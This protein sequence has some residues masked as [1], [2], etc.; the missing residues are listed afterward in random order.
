M[1]YSIRRTFVALCAGLGLIAHAHAKPPVSAFSD[2]PDVRAA[3]LSPD[4][5][6]VAFISHNDGVDS[7]AIFDF[8]T[9]ET[10]ALSQVTDL[11]VRDISFV[12]DRYL[13]LLVSRTMR[14]FGV[15]DQWEQSAAFS[16][17]LQE[18]DVVKLLQRTDGLYPYQS[19]L[20]R[21]VGVH[22]DGDRV[23]M[24]AFMGENN[25]QAYLGLLAVRLDNGRG[26]EIPG[27]RGRHD[28]IDW[29]ISPKGEPLAREDLNGRPPEHEIWSY[30]RGSAKE[31]YSDES[32]I[33]GISLI[34]SLSEDEL[35]TID[36]SDTGYS[37][38][39]SMSATTGETQGP[40]LNR[41]D[42]DIGGVITDINRRA[43]GVRYTGMR[44][45]YDMFD[46]DLTAAIKTVQDA[47]PQS[48]IWLDSWSS[49][50]SK[51]LFF[52]EGG[53]TPERYVV[54]DRTSGAVQ[55]IINARPQ[56]TSAD[57]GESVEM[58]YFARDDL[59]IPGVLTWPAGSTEA[60]RT[61][62]P[63]VVLP[64]GGPATYDGLGW[65]WLAQ[66][67][68]NEGYAVFQ[69][70]FRGSTGFG[71][72]HHRAGRR[73]WGRKMQ[74]DIT[75][76]VDALISTGWIDPERICIVGWSYGGYAALMGAVRTPDKYKCAASIAGVS[77]LREML[78]HERATGSSTRRVLAYWEH[79]IGDIDAD[80]AAINAISPVNLTDSITAPVL[81]VHGDDDTVVQA[82]QSDLM[83]RALEAAGKPVEYLRIEGDDHNLTFPASRNAV[84]TRLRAFLAEHLAAE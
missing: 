31:I 34:G 11:K 64:H 6:R 13:L 44:P 84:L 3:E 20:G 72:D 7:L 4:G 54:L 77:D 43:L 66:F 35:L 33:A 50:H 76:G 19:G 28:T 21:V 22:P 74:D 40:I 12:S 10:N 57:I 82:R 80:A 2:T 23:F 36:S 48:S 51:L 39:Y 73:E 5:S 37:A 9:G 32:S 70:N 30:A 79:L 18:G 41:N 24:P 1:P 17:D 60:D 46:P 56:F 27:V 8:A 71:R 53:E 69:P 49:D 15:V 78:R 81:L 16:F 67:I 47:L 63:M 14:R 61:A 42:A 58:H 83:H 55:T 26:F 62:L 38:L 29:I 65:D 25:N 45:T 68:A 59:K 52:V 75:D